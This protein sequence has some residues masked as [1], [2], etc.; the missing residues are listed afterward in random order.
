MAFS[1]L[2]CFFTS[3]LSSDFLCFGRSVCS[4]PFFTSVV[5]GDFLEIIYIYTYIF[6]YVETSDDGPVI[7]PKYLWVTL[8]AFLLASG[9]CAFSKF[10]WERVWGTG[11]LHLFGQPDGCDHPGVRCLVFRW[12]DGIA[13]KMMW[14]NLLYI[15]CFTCTSKH[16]V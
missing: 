2:F 5:I 1:V 12:I 4:S 10:A 8:G 14:V 13:S 16:F 7:F 11:L 3:V 15:R 6:Q 9:V